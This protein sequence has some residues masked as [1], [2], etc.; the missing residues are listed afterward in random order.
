MADL[1]VAAAI[2]RLNANL[3]TLLVRI[4]K[5]LEKAEKKKKG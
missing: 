2:D 4:L 1:E 5:A 3:S